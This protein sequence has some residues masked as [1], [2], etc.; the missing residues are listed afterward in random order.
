MTRYAI[1]GVPQM[2]RQSGPLGILKN[3]AAQKGMEHA[4]DMYAPGA[5]TIGGAAVRDLA[6]QLMPKF[7]ED[8]GVAEESKWAQLVAQWKALQDATEEADIAGDIARIGEALGTTSGQQQLMRQGGLEAVA[9]LYRQKGGPISLN[10]ANK[11]KFTAKAK[12]AGEGVQEYASKVLSAPEGRYPASTRRQANFA[13][14]AAKWHNMGGMIE[15]V[16]HHK[17][18]DGSMMQGAVHRA[19]GGRVGADT[20]GAPAN[21]KADGGRIGADTFGAPA[22]YRNMGGPLGGGQTESALK[23]ARQLGALS[24]KEFLKAMEHGGYLKGS[25]PLAGVKYKQQGGKITNEAEVKFHNPLMG[26]SEK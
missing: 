14:N 5:G 1:Q 11:G 13:K 16:T 8:G 3:Y 22:N 10:P 4:I 25:G 18:P 21:Y 24:Q 15:G 19:G 17:M 23:E 7:L 2:Q 20:F 12:A 6:P 9:N 26:K